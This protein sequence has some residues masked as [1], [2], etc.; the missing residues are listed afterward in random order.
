VGLSAWL[1]E[2]A[3]LDLGVAF[4]VGVS[5]AGID[6]KSAMTKTDWCGQPVDFRYIAAPESVREIQ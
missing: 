5:V 2:E 3:D 1:W 4:V 6:M